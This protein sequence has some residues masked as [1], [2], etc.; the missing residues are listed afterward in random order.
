MDLKCLIV[1]CARLVCLLAFSVSVDA[2]AARPMIT[3]APHWP[4][5]VAPDVLIRRAEFGML[6]T[7]EQGE[8]QFIATAA[9]PADSGQVFGWVLQVDTPRH[10][11]RW[12]EH[13]FLPKAPA[14]WGD[15]STD[16]DVVISADGESA[17]SQGEEEVVQGE[18]SRFYWTLAEGD[19]AGEY[20]L[21]LAI[22]GSTV[23]H[24]VFQVPATVQE[25]PLLVQGAEGSIQRIAWHAPNEEQ[26]SWK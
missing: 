23:M 13:L 26:S 2:A 20:R 24:F 14:D 5:Q 8:D 15:A 6:T 22:E 25:K 9:L 10:T 1:P 16:P 21:D 11:L 19:P 7:N 4:M 17:A 18:L 3:G 12:Q